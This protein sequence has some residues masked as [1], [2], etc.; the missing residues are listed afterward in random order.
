MKFSVIIFFPSLIFIGALGNSLAQPKLK[1]DKDDPAIRARIEWLRLHD[2]TTGKIPLHIRSRELEFVSHLPKHGGGSD[3]RQPNPGSNILKT[4][5]WTPRGPFNIG[6]RTRAVGID[7]KNENVIL[8][9]GVSGG[10]WRSPDGGNS[11]TRRTLLTEQPEVSCLVQ[12][13]RS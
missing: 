1:N 9:G 10:M 3:L 12:D 11:W 2:P 6:G 5:S 4:D 13:V 7:I 8:A